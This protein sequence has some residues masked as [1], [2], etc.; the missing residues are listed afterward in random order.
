LFEDLNCDGTPD[1]VLLGPKAVV[2]GQ[3]VCVVVSTQTS[4]GVGPSAS[5]TYGITAS[6]A[7]SGTAVTD[8]VRNDDA[9]GAG[10]GQELVLRK[11]VTNLTKASGEGTTNSGDLGDVL[12]YR[13]VM[14]NPSNEA[15]ADVVVYDETPAYTA[16]NGPVPSPITLANGVT[17][18]LTVPSSNVAGYSGPLQWNCPGSF[19]PGGEG[20]VTFDVQ[21][22]P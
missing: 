3:Q 2:A 11:L 4:A 12:R 9:I 8:L 7:F 16:L 6:T 1:Q 19:P 5:Y 17:C 18:A 21:I 15:A 10:T 22:S 20:S 13:I 14:S